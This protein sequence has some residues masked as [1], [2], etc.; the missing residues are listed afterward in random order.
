MSDQSRWPD[1]MIQQQIVVEAA[2]GAIEET[3]HCRRAEYQFPKDDLA[4][5]TVLVEYDTGEEFVLT[6]RPLLRDQDPKPLHGGSMNPV[7]IR[8]QG[9]DPDVTV[10]RMH[11]GIGRTDQ[12]NKLLTIVMSQDEGGDVI[13]HSVLDED[14]FVEALRLL[15]PNG[16]LSGGAEAVCR[17]LVDWWSGFDDNDAEGTPAEDAEEIVAM[18]QR[19]LGAL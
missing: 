18:A 14:S 13:G 11:I 9:S 1:H 7:T 17:A 8:C 12:F 6:V 16:E 2:V 15:F 10:G 5:T 19:V 4:G 3:D